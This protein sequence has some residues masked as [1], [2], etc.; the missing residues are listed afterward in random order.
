M[1]FQ[2]KV[3]K[4]NSFLFK[5]YVFGIALLLAFY[6]R[7]YN[8]QEIIKHSHDSIVASSR[9]FNYWIEVSISF[10]AL[11][12]LI[13]ILRA[14]NKNSIRNVISK[15]QTFAGDRELEINDDLVILHSKLS[16]TEYQFSA[17]IKLEE[18]NDYYFIY[19]DKMVAIV[20]PK[21]TIGSKEF[22]ELFREKT[23][24]NVC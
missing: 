23:K 18:I 15:N 11:I 13:F 10:A 12:G 21:R 17:F 4:E 2:K 8:E 5:P 9:M 20:I 3:L 7:Y 14:A 19:T 22:I 6:F 1:A 16:R 24:I